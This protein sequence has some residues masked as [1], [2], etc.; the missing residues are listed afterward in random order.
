M[1]PL[2]MQKAICFLIWLDSF[3][4]HLQVCQAYLLPCGSADK[5]VSLLHALGLQ[6][7]HSHYM[8]S[9]VKQTPQM[10]RTSPL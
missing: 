4:Y 5:E 7:I 9:V 2:E 1:K 8:V 6:I 10:A 3:D